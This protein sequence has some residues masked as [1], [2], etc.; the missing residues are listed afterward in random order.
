MLNVLRSSRSPRHI[1]LEGGIA[2]GLGIV[3]SLLWMALQEQGI[4]PEQLLEM[5]QAQG[6][7]GGAPA[8]EEGMMP[9]EEAA[10]PKMGSSKRVTRDL[11]NLIKYSQSYRRAGRFSFTEAKTAQQRNLRDQIKMCV[12]DIVG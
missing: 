8:P 2:I 12:R 1:R 7:E 11:V 5:I 3:M 6:G 10:M 4:E 9:P